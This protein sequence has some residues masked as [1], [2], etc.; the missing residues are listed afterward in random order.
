MPVGG[1]RIETASLQ[2]DEQ[3]DKPSESASPVKQNVHLFYQG[4]VF[5]NY[6]D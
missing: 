5:D 3:G 2:S 6:S 1:W 4:G